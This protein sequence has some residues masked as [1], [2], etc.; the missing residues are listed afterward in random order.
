MVENNSFSNALSA[1][2]KLHTVVIV[3][4]ITVILLLYIL[5]ELYFINFLT[6]YRGRACD[7]MHSVANITVSRVHVFHAQTKFRGQFSPSYVLL[8]AIHQTYLDSQD[9]SAT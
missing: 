4:Y 6:F 2:Y 1:I 5:Y 7:I 8:T 3:L 9:F